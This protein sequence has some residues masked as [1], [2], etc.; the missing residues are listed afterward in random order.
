MSFGVF[1]S[2]KNQRNFCQDFRPGRKNLP[3]KGRS[4]N[5]MHLCLR[6][7]LSPID[8]YVL[9]TKIS[10]RWTTKGPFLSE[11]LIGLKKTCQ[12]TILNFNF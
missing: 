10:L 12:I 1:N 4:I 3:P 11:N 8:I 6:K 9:C 7:T 2:P 5:C